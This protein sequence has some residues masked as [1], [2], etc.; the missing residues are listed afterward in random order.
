MC[1]LGWGVVGVSLG[2]KGLTLD[3]PTL[4]SKGGIE[5]MGEAGIRKSFL[6]YFNTFWL[7]YL[8]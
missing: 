3:P 8:V 7:Q 6:T 4:V 1:S 5:G 2:K